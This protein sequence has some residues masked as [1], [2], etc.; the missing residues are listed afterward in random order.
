TGRFEEGLAEIKRAEELDPLSLREMTLTSWTYYQVRRYE[1]AVR[2]AR[3]ITNLDKYN[4]QGHMQMGNALL[5][6]GEAE[7]ALVALRESVRL[8]PGAALPICILCFALVAA[9]RQEEAEQVRNELKAT[10][11]RTYV[12]EYFLALAHL[13]LGDRDQALTNLEK[14]AA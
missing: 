11:E 14:A 13:A 9:G 1:D 6:M 8:M 2:K 12:K 4:F 10:A 7:K 3:Q 5:E